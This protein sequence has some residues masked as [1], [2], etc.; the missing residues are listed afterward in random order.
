MPPTAHGEP[1]YKFLFMAKGGGSANK[2]FLFQETKAVL[3]PKRDAGV[4]RREDPLARHRRLPAVPPGRSSSAAPRAEFA[5]KTAK[6]ASAHYLD[7]LPTEGSMAGHGFRDPELEAAGLRADPGLRH[8]RTVRRQVLLPRRPRH[9]APPPRRLLPGRDR[10]VVLGRP[11]G[12]G[13][14]HRRG[15]LPRA[16]R[17]RPGALPARSAGRPSDI[18]GGEVVQIDLNQPMAEILAELSQVPRQD[19]AVADRPARRG[20]RHRARQDQGAARRRRGD[21]GVPQEP[22]GLLRRPG[23]DPGRHGVAAPSARR[24]P[25]GWTPTSISSRPPAARW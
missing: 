21:A 22:P 3:N 9:P 24:P 4:P 7:N 17:D 10:G 19:A 20:P 1:A 2:S 5:L 15:R 23:Q 18:S 25:A 8:R 12:A 13:Q 11:P 16:A 14:D 6:Y